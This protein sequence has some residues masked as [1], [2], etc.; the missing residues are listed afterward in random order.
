MNR[1]LSYITININGTIGEQLF[2][3]SNMLSI[4]Y[5][6]RDVNK[7]KIILNKNDNNKLNN[8]FNNVFK[9]Y[10]YNEYG[11]V[12]IDNIGEIGDA[13][14]NN[15]A[16]KNYKKVFDDD[17]KNKILNIAYN[18]EDMMY[19][20]YYKYRDILKHFGDDTTDDDMISLDYKCGNEEYY[21]TALNT[22]DKKNIVIFGNIGNN[23]DN[24]KKKFEKYNCY[25]I[26]NI[27]DISDISDIAD[28]C[29]S[30]NNMCDGVR[31]ILMSMFK[32]NIIS[33]SLE[34]LWASYI[35]YY[36]NKIVIA[37]KEIEYIGHKNINIYI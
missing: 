20:A 17:I 12:D 3:I 37:P 2:Q 22:I 36:E 4:K 8:M 6:K 13:S 1:K 35:S 9:F 15:V 33:N 29:D 7:V 18:N 25:Y 19:S 26:D 27:S 24:D 23:N 31:L 30:G 10:E 32:H 16:I 28:K 5:K 34:S 21:K 14:I 11:F